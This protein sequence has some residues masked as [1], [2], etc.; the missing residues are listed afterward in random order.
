MIELEI[1]QLQGA[2]F[3]S[4]PRGKKAPNFSNWHKLPKELSSFNFNNENI[5]IILGKDGNGIV[6]IDFDGDSTVPFF[7]KL[8]D[9]E[10]PTTVAFT[11]TRPGR[12]QRLFKISEEYYTYLSLKQIKTGT[13]DPDGK[14]Q[15]LELRGGFNRAAQSVLPPSFVSDDYNSRT[16]TWVDGLSPQD[17]EIAQLPDQIL[18]YW[19]T[20]CNDID[21]NTTTI[22]SKEIPNTE[23]MLIHLAETLH[24]F[25]PRLSY[26][27]WIR[28]AWGFKNSSDEPTA[29]DLMKYYWPETVKNEYKKLFKSPPPAK[30][31]TVGTIRYLIKQAGGAAAGNDTEINLCNLMNKKN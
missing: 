17:V 16:Y 26:N 13:N 30:K 10:L 29:T 24:K 2:R 23:P 3:V 31:C 21:T 22:E 4:I 6:A 19:L 28:V 7:K 15:Q 12:H 9:I 1:L 25:Y 18:S 8:F 11:S 20:L 5:G 14:H 27:D